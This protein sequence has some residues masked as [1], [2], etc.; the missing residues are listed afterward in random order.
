[1]AENEG[2]IPE[3]LPEIVRPEK[4]KTSDPRDHYMELD[5]LRGIAILGVVLFHLTSYWMVYVRVPLPL[6]LL[7][8]DALKLF[9]ST[10]WGVSLFFLLSGYLL[11]WTEEKRARSGAY[12]VRSYALRRMLRLV[13]A[14]YFA[15]LV[16]IVVWPERASVMGVLL[17]MSFL[18]ALNPYT[19][20]ALD[21]VWWSLTAEVVFYVLLPFLVVKLPR[22]SQRLTLFGA[23][24]VISLSTRMII[25]H[26][27]G[28]PLIQPDES[29]LL[30]YLYFLPT[31][32]LWLFLAGVLLRMVVERLGARPMSRLRP[33]LASVLFLVSA[34]FLVTLPY[35]LGERAMKMPLDLMMVAFFASAVLG[36]PLL[37]GVL[38]W[39]PLVFVGVISYSLFLLHHAVIEVIFRPFLDDVRDWIVGRGDLAA[40]VAFSAYSFGVLAAAIA[41]SYLSYRCIESPFLRHKPK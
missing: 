11:T 16:A 12:S 25:W 26:V 40:W 27:A 30:R 9:H 8:E 22:F 4:I 41:V 32:W 6:P 2:R 1:M 28:Q 15:I 18:Q 14:Y 23:L 29:G 5:A 39:R 38:S 17:Q 35:L 34:F 13:P 3:V 10:G 19:G 33:L 37:R 21:P 7:R 31:T 20:M 24:F 36:A